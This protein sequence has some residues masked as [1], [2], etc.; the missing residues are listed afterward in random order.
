MVMQGRQVVPAR[1][2]LETSEASSGSSCFGSAERSMTSARGPRVSRTLAFVASRYRLALTCRGSMSCH[3]TFRVG[4]HAQA[5]HGRI[6]RWSCQKQVLH[7]TCLQPAPTE[8]TSTQH[9][10]ITRTSNT[11][12]QRPPTCKTTCMMH[13]ETSRIPKRHLPHT[14]QPTPPEHTAR[15]THSKV[16]RLRRLRQL[17]APCSACA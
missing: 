15:S 9:T 11:H 14:K 4:A 13:P 12:L 5:R 16:G 2:L 1:G 17:L 3:A 6:K 7:P 8:H 10:P